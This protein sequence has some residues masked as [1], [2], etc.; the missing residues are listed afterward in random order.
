MARYI[1]NFARVPT[2]D[3][4]GVVTNSDKVNVVDSS[5]H[6]VLLEGE[7]EEIQ[8]L[9]AGIRDAVAPSKAKSA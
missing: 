7:K 6:M 8:K 1:V 5:K 4:L 3:E 2:D 9:A